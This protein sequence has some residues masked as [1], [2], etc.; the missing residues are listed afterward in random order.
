MNNSFAAAQMMHCN[1]LESFAS[2][3]AG[4]WGK[5]LRRDWSKWKAENLFQILTRQSLCLPLTLSLSFS[6]SD[7]SSAGSSRQDA[8]AA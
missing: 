6:T 3:F 4:D 2:F 7:G 8:S 5:K 1:S